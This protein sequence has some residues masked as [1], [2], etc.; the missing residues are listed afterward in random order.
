[1]R[2]MATIGAVLVFILGIGIFTQL[3]RHG[4]ASPGTISVQSS[5]SARGKLVEEVYNTTRDEA[6]LP[7]A[8]IPATPGLPPEIMISDEEFDAQTETRVDPRTVTPDPT[9]HP[10]YREPKPWWVT[11]LDLVARVGFT[12]VFVVIGMLL[13]AWLIIRSRS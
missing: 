1:M 2:N 8:A 5:H 12:I 10:D 9:D 11:L 7:T 6:P 13:V 3:P 4:A